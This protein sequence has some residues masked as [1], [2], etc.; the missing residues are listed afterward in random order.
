V[1]RRSVRFGRGRL[2]LVVRWDNYNATVLST[3]QKGAIAETAI[4]H[5]ATKLGIPVAKPILPVPY[6]LIFDLG[7]RL[8]RVQCKWANRQGG[9]VFI[10]C[11]RSRRGREGLIQR[12]YS[13]V[14]VD[15]FAA[16][17]AELD[18]CYFLPIEPFASR[19][20]IQL[21]LAPARNN[22]QERINWAEAY[23]FDATLAQFG[24][25]AQLGERLAGSQ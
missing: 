13:P 19:L 11:R 17:C 8:V 16:Y 1:G 22:Q 3:D 12:L 4:I 6:D 21:R 2:G 5:E 15:A 20:G 18:R 25:V 9:V 7:T 14:E 24:A 23:E 10:R